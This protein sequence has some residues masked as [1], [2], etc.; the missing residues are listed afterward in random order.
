MIADDPFGKNG[1]NIEEFLSSKKNNFTSANNN[2]WSKNQQSQYS[3][4]QHNQNF[5]QPKSSSS[6]NNHSH[7]SGNFSGM[8]AFNKQ[9]FSSNQFKQQYQ[10]SQYHNKIDPKVRTGSFSNLSSNSSN[11]LSQN[12]NT[13]SLTGQTEYAGYWSTLSKPRDM[14]ETSSLYDKL[15][16]IFPNSDAKIKSLLNS[17]QDNKDLMFFIEKCCE[18]TDIK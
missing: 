4:Y 15:I 12:S 5:A 3:Y 17:N 7:S 14:S 1:P 13:K 16:D 18:E 6:V 10:N 2:Q 9:S 11:D 8:T